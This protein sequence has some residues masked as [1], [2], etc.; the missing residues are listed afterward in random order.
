MPKPKQQKQPREKRCPANEKRRRPAR[1][2]GVSA[3]AAA[4]LPWNTAASAFA[5]PADVA[6]PFCASLS[7]P[8]N[9]PGDRNS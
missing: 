8:V 9:L 7:F 4:D 5:A 6:L 3:R 1:R 2:F